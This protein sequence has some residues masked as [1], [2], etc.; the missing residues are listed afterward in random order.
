[1]G[2]GEALADRIDGIMGGRPGWELEPQSSPGSALLW[3]L[4]SEDDPVLTVGAEEGRI[5]VYLV[6]A[7]MEFLLADPEALSA[8]LAANEPLFTVRAA[9]P[10]ST[11]EQIP[12]GRVADWRRQGL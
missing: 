2:N 7:D 5:S 3:C 8:W 1:M 10:E 6:E 9:M 12:A 4:R 11:Y